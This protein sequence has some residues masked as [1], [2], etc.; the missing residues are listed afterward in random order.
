MISLQR[1]TEAFRL[2]TIVAGI[3]CVTELI[4]LRL[5]ACS[6]ADYAVDFRTLAVES[7]WNQEA[8]FNMFLH[9]A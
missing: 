3:G 9:G 8:L 6:E 5:D 1:E 2:D 7:A 4:Q